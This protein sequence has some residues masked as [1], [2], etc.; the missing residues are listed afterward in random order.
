MGGADDTYD[1]GA[2]TANNIIETDTCGFQV[3]TGANFGASSSLARRVRFG[4]SEGA[5]VDHSTGDIM[6]A[7]S[8]DFGSQALTLYQ[9]NIDV[10][11]VQVGTFRYEST[12][13]MYLEEKQVRVAVDGL[14]VFTFSRAPVVG[15]GMR[16]D[17]AFFDTG[18]V[19]DEMRWLTLLHGIS[20][21]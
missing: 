8:V 16:V 6:Y 10:G 4:L 15:A 2:Y 18:V 5:N 1:E 21:N 11:S 14:E 12:V 17:T 3:K 20:A 7:A 19:L 13:A 9:D